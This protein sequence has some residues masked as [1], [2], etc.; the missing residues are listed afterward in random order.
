MIMFICIKQHRSDIRSSTDEKLRNTKG[1]L[2]KS[3]AYK[4]RV[5]VF[6]YSRC[7]KT[8]KNYGLFI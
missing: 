3:V 8:L 7:Y 1:E 4:K 2:K 5:L 6:L